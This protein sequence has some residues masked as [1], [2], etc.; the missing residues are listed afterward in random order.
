MN[1]A[2]A[3][4]DTIDA[5][6]HHGRPQYRSVPAISGIAGTQRHLAVVG[7]RFSSDG[8]HHARPVRAVLVANQSALFAV[9][10]LCNWR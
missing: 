5:S 8:R 4:N 1:Q 2:C 3:R 10:C 9:Y 6:N 7:H